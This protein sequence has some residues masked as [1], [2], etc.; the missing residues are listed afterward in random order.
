MS[1]L[2]IYVS[3]HV[4]LNRIYGINKLWLWLFRSQA[5]DTLSNVFAH[6]CC[7]YENQ[8]LNTYS[9]L[10]NFVSYVLLWR[11]HICFYLA[12]PALLYLL[13]EWKAV[14]NVQ[15]FSRVSNFNNVLFV[16][17]GSIHATFH[18]V[19]VKISTFLDI[20]ITWKF[21]KVHH[22]PMLST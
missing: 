11:K 1:C 14:R 16:C 5:K 3:W 8:K 12:L 7:M 6:N 17:W 22:Q 19:I 21:T 2:C 4:W 13:Q 15:G 10:W 9:R 20:S 18:I